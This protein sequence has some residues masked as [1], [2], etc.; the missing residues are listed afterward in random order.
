M[1]MDAIWENAAKGGCGFA[2][3]RRRA[4]LL[5]NPAAT[6]ELLRDGELDRFRRLAYWGDG[7]IYITGRAKDVIIKGGRN[8]YPH[9]VEQIAGRVA[10]VRTDA[11]WRSARRMSARD[12]AVVVAAELRDVAAA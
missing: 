7:E 2:G 4:A 1:R 5:P 12:G 9:E 11:W 8:L 10:G 6:R 3:L